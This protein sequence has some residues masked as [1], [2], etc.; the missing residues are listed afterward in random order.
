MKGGLQINILHEYTDKNQEMCE[1]L[2]H[3]VQMVIQKMLD[4][5]IG[6]ANDIFRISVE[7]RKKIHQHLSRHRKSGKIQN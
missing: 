5:N 3:Q 6:K 7:I 4:L 1:K 2:M